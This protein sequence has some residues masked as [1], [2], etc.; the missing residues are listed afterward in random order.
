M[1]P[2]IITT[3]RQGKEYHYLA[4]VESYREKGKIKQ[5]QVGNL[6]NIDMYSE[7]EILSLINKLRSLLRGS[8][9]RKDQAAPSSESGQYRRP[10]RSGDSGPDQ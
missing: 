6:G 8:G 5:R 7:K 4:M 10:K 2:R 9:E 1:F 3:K